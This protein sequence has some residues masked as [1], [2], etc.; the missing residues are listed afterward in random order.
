MNL[1]TTED[2][3]D[4]EETLVMSSVSGVSSVVESL[5]TPRTQKVGAT[6]GRR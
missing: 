5:M 1:S 6:R 4:T 2:T 3:E